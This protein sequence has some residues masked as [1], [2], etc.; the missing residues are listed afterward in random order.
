VE[1]V[2]LLLDF[3]ESVEVDGSTVYDPTAEAAVPAVVL[4]MPRHRAAW[5]GL[6]LDSYARVCQLVGGDLDAAERGPA[7]ALALAA[8][9]VGHVNPAEPRTIGWVTSGRRLAVAAVLRSAEDFN[10]T[11]TIAVVD[12]VA[13]WLDEP[14]GNEYAY[15]LLGA[16]TDGQT[17]L[18]AYA[19]LV[20]GGAR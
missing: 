10:D 2:R 18:R 11:T 4:R 13:R 8:Q 6:V 12:A 14:G 7:W 3:G 16:V 9:S 15:A 19:T 5:F 17:Q 20:D 1:P